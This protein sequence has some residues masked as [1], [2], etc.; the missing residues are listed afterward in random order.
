MCWI[1]NPGVASSNPIPATYLS[2]RF[3]HKIISMAILS[4]LLVQIGQLSVTGE[5]MDTY[6]W[7]TAQEECG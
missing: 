2:Y 3:G 5:S 4:L 6:Y 1:C 7:L